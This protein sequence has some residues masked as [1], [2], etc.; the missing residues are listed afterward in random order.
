MRDR[1]LRWTKD[2]MQAIW[3]GFSTFVAACLLL[4]LDYELLAS[5]PWY[6][7]IILFLLAT[8]VARSQTDIYYD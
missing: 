1:K 5:V 4:A 2:E 8:M 3:W 6:T 7:V